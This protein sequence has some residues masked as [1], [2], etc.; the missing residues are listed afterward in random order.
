MCEARRRG[1]E[2][3]GGE[4]IRPFPLLSIPSCIS[5][6]N[7]SRSL[8]HS[9]ASLTDP[10]L[11]RSS[12]PPSLPHFTSLTPSLPTSILC[13]LAFFSSGGG[14]GERVLCGGTGKNGREGSQPASNA[15]PE[16]KGRG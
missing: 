11:I 14:G 7:H 9:P 2:E 13:V 15:K 8:S 4:E 12:S 10:C 3:M 1:G 6:H 5:S 16:G